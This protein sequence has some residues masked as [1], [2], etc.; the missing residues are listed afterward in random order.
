MYRRVVP[1]LAVIICLAGCSPA[2]TS[3]PRYGSPPA[4]AQLIQSEYDALLGNYVLPLDPS[5]LGLAAATGMGEAVAQQLGPTAAEQFP[6]ASFGDDGGTV[7][8]QIA[9]EYVAASKAFPQVDSV[10]L[11]HDAMASMAESINDCHTN[12][13]TQAQYQEQQ[14]ELAGTVQFGG[15]GA[16]LKD[17]PGSTPL[18]ADVFAGLPAAKAGVHP[19]DAIAQVNGRSVQGMAASAV[20][21]LI[22]G[23]VG[24]VV[25]LDV[26]RSGQGTL[27][28]SITREDV[29]P[30]ALSTGTVAVGTGTPIGYAHIYGFTTGMPQLLQQDL[31]QFAQRG[32]TNW[33]LD[34][35]DNSGGT[36]QSLV[37]TASFFIPQGPIAQFEDRTGQSDQLTTTGQGPTLVPQKMVLLVNHDSASASEIFAA[38]LQE[39]AAVPVVGATTAG[40]VAVGK[41]QTLADG[42]AIEYAVDRVSTPVQHR[43]L[44][45]AG[46]VPDVQAAMSLDDLAAGKDPQLTAAV[47]VLEG[48]AAPTANP[49][50]PAPAG[51]AGGGGAAGKIIPGAPTPTGA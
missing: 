2:V 9:Q 31:Q 16:S 3:I 5:V 22:R 8:R 34:L 15:I 10:T 41:F 45:G 50:S 6:Y 11:A 38:A 27:H 25:Q 12:F 42:S 21:N 49:A 20:V 26:Q 37:Q 17:R 36:L 13:F 33:I 32:I 28:F 40:C 35:R 46:V 24:S 18:I 1:L 7:R 48:Q 43:V 23:P 30:P 39:R 29:A 47:A 4:E 51:T 14:A 44:N 19:G